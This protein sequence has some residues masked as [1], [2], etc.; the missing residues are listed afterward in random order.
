[1][2][3][4]VTVGKIWGIIYPELLYTFITYVFMI[5]V[6]I[7][8]TV[9]LMMNGDFNQNTLMTGVTNQAM[10]ITLWSALVTLPFLIMFRWSDIKH[11]KLNGRYI[12]YQHVFIF[13][14]LWIIPFGILCMLSSNAL[15]NGL[16]TAFPGWVTESYQNLEKTIYGSSFFIQVLSAGIICPIVEEMIYR[17]LIYNRIKKITGVMPAAILSSIIF[18]AFHGNMVQAVYAFLI[19]LVCVFVYEKYKSIVAPIFLHISAN[20]FSLMISS[21]SAGNTESVESAAAISQIQM[22]VS[23]IFIAV[24]TGVAALGL[25]IIIKKTV[26]PK[27]IRK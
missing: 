2:R 23:Y 5:C 27:E 26:N 7:A 13:K 4:K 18:G 22:M 20:M 12:K 11:E 8:L 24:V 25:G 10:L 6:T 9:V 19:G 15:V 3:E 14:Y 21:L 1:M 16:V 17:S